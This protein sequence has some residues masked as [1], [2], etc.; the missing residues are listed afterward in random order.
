M[1]LGDW[2]DG[3]LAKKK[4]KQEH[5]GVL[6]SFRVQY[7]Q[8]KDLLL[9]N[10][11]LGSLMAEIDEKLRGTSLFGISEIRAL[12]TRSVFHTMRMVTA[13]N[14]ISGNRYANLPD[15]VEHINTRITGILDSKP[16]QPVS[17]YTFPLS[18]VDKTQV[19]IVGGKCA[20]LGEMRN[21]A[22]IPTPPGFAIT[23][24]AYN[25]FLQSEGLR[26]EILKLLREAQPD[27]PATV[28]AV[29]ESIFRTIDQVSVPRDIMDALLHAW[30]EVQ[31]IRT[32][33]HD[34]GEPTFAALTC[35]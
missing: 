4:T 23:T 26:D 15:M 22:N 3:I 14:V 13:L 35:D 30:G 17:E 27:A 19:D 8:F 29:S 12:A 34:G 5:E 9:S 10:A 18:A 24:G 6:R 21:H 2:L 11:E 7:T 33:F 25:R 32:R 16:Q 28:V 1:G 20:N 31:Q